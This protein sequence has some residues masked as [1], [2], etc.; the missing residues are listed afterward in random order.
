MAPDILSSGT[1][2]PE[3]E[4]Q[5]VFV[6]ARESAEPCMF[7][8]HSLD[9]R[10][11]S[12]Q[13]STTIADMLAIDGLQAQVRELQTA[14]ARANEDCLI[15]QR[16]AAADRQHLWRAI[17]DL[18]LGL[19]ALEGAHSPAVHALF[20]QHIA[21]HPYGVPYSIIRD[22][23]RGVSHQQLQAAFEDL[24]STGAAYRTHSDR[25]YPC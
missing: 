7:N 1:D 16:R 4:L 15:E 24:D 10:S 11:A 8:I 23:F 5:P 19:D 13:T 21:R 3:S 9:T 12:T 18:R 22:T 17:A 25:W 6:D 20:L 14:I 2:Q